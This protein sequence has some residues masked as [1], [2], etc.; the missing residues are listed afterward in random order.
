M[1]QLQTFIDTNG[2]TLSVGCATFIVE[3][4]SGEPDLAVGTFR[5]ARTSYHGVTCPRAT[6]AGKPGAEVWAVI[7]GRSTRASFAIWNGTLI[8]LR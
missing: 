4:I 6:V 8:P 5:S 7:G 2:P 3:G 1:T